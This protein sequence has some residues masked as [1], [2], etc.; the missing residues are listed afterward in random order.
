MSTKVYIETGVGR[1]LIGNYG[2]GVLTSHRNSSKH[3]YK[4][5][6]AWGIDC[7]V[8]DGLLKDRGL[9]TVIIHDKDTNIT[10]TTKAENFKK[11]GTILHFKPHRP[12]VFLPL[13]YWEH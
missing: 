13:D 4:K 5:L 7:K 3:L 6:N 12:Q 9:H 8:Y 11:Y 1:R 2:D 10:Y